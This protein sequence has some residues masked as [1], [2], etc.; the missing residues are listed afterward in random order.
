[1]LEEVCHW[2]GALREGHTRS[3]VL[4]CLLFKGQNVKHSATTPA[5]SHSTSHH[6]DHG[7]TP[8]TKQAPMKCYSL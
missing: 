6:V 3:S 4:L 1:M 8:E 7:L 5:T 2:G